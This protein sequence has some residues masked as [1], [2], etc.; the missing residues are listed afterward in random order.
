MYFLPKTTTI[1]STIH[2]E[3]V[4]LMSVKVDSF[5]KLLIFNYLVYIYS[6]HCAV[7]ICGCQI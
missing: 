6:I 2:L 5:H 4:L 3:N 1:H 7:L